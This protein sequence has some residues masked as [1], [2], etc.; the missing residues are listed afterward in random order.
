METMYPRASAEVETQVFL[1]LMINQL[2]VST[3]P[4]AIRRQ[5]T[6]VNEIPTGLFVRADRQE[7]AGVIAG[8]L[9]TV[10]SHSR[11]SCIRI[12][13]RV[14]DRLLQL[15]I[16]GGTRLSGHLFSTKLG[17]IERLAQRIGAALQVSSNQR[18]ET[19]ISLN[20]FNRSLAA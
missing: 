15:R 19:T 9:Q 13:A 3:L 12:S 4:S 1:S 18:N 10:I 2:S 5:S 14:Y 17:E 6:I 7:L 20:I 8:L 11:D 16:E